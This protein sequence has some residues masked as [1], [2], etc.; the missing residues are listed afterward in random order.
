MLA[1]DAVDDVAGPINGKLEAIRESTY[2]L[3][4]MLIKRNGSWLPDMMIPYKRTTTVNTADGT[5]IVA[6]G[7]NWNTYCTITQFVRY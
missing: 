3:I 5:E 4:T 7:S 1:I 6:A 2:P